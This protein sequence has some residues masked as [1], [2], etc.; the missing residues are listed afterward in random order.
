VDLDAGTISVWRSGRAHGDTKT[1]PSRR[2]VKLP[3]NDLG[4]TVAAVGM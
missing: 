3:E 1:N 4:G 2:T